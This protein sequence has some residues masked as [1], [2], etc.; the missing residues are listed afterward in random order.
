MTKAAMG[1]L[2]S[3]A[4]FILTS[5]TSTTPAEQ[6]VTRAQPPNPKVARLPEGIDPRQ[7]SDD[8]TYGYK[9]SNPIQVGGPEGFSGPASEQLYLR[10]L[11]D[12]Q[13][14][15][16][17]FDR[18]GSVG[19]G[20]DGHILDLY[21]ITSSDGRKYQLYMDMYHPGIHPFHVNAPEGLHFW[22]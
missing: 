6:H 14:K 20:P 5:C 17:K 21:E 15:P 19:S 11:R 9:K 10:H 22:K 12:S 8:P 4:V 2:V 16:C 13:F 18:L 7:T 3:G 1:I